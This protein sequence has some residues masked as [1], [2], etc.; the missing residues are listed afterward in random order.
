MTDEPSLLNLPDNLPD[1]VYASWVGALTALRESPNTALANER[2]QFCTAYLQ[3]LE[4]AQIIDYH[5]G[6]MLHAEVQALSVAVRV[7]L[8]TLVP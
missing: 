3:A 7:V 2:L 5:I 1:N 8:G 4:D 6:R